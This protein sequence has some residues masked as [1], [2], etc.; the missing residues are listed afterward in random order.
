MADAGGGMRQAIESSHWGIRPYALILG[1]NEIASAVAVEMRR[2]GWTV[3]LGHDPFPPV[4]RRKMA[5][6]D[7]LFGDAV[8]IDNV[9]GTLAE[10]A[11]EVLDAL[12]AGARVVVTPLQLHDLI[13]LR[14]PDV[15]IDGRMQKYR[16]TPDWRHIAPMTIGLGPN[17]MVGENCDIAIETKPTRSGRLIRRGSAEQAN[18]TPQRLGGV[19]KERFEY[20]SREGLWHM[21]VDIG[22]RVFKGFVV[23]RLEGLPVRAPIDGF[24][25]GVVRDGSRIPAGVKVLEIDPRGRHAQWTGIDNRSNLIAKAVLKATHASNLEQAT[26]SISA[27]LT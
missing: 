25:R 1:T 21:A 9:Q 10:D 23:G 7:V 11:I 14:T 27:L 15:L 24:V 5:F 13:A 19:G 2:A 12:K 16:T 20:A 26:A 3:V 4:I 6:H 18:H 17:F 22:I 8:V